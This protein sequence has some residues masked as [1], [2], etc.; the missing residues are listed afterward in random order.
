MNTRCAR[1]RSGCAS[2]YAS[3]RTAGAG[4]SCS[5]AC[6]VLWN[7][8]PLTTPFSAS[9]LARTSA[10]LPGWT[11]RARLSCAFRL[12][13][14]SWSSSWPDCRSASS[15]LK[16]AAG[17]HLL[18]RTCASQ[19]HTGVNRPCNCHV[20]RI[21]QIAENA[22]RAWGCCERRTRATHTAA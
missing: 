12:T 1:S 22:P 15:R 20:G 8:L 16:P 13:R 5:A 18:S 7:G 11:W 9:T 14:E 3:P 10:A 19:G 21:T 2:N 17:Q 6:A 4:L